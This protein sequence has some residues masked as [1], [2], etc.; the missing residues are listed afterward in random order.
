IQE[1]MRDYSS[2]KMGFVYSGFIGDKGWSAAHNEARKVLEYDLK[3]KTEY[4]ENVFDSEQATIAIQKLI[5]NGCNVIS[6]C[7]IL[8][9]D[10]TFEAA[11]N[12]PDIYFFNCAGSVTAENL[13]TF[14][15]KEYQTSYLC[16][17]VAGM[18]TQTNKIGYVAAM[19]VPETIRGINAF[20]LG[21]QSVNPKSEVY[22]KWVYSWYN[23]AA[24]KS[25]AIELI[26]SNCDVIAQHQNTTNCQLAAQQA[27]NNGKDVWC[28]G[29]HLSNYDD[30]PDAYLTA[31]L[32]KYADYYKEQLRQIV[33]GTWK[34][35][36][37]WGGIEDTIVSID[38]LSQNCAEGTQEKVNEAQQKILDGTEKIFSGPLYDNYGHLKVLD[39]EFMTDEQILSFDWFVDGVNP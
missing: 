6:T 18:R 11:K 31:T 25:S 10:A 21:A 36:S 14:F 19:M 29:E 24:E 9:S 32:F 16:G 15:C 26:N 1:D 5:D 7:S 22:V 33:D 12:N 13:S 8:F 30:A 17:I 28:I 35:S 37:Y 27:Q 23:P 39:G 3:L 20:A 34:S 38:K 2:I 4:V